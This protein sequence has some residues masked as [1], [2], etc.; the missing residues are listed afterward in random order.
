MVCTQGAEFH[1]VNERK[2]AETQESNDKPLTN[3]DL[4]ELDQLILKGGEI[5]KDDAKTGASMRV[6]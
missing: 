6:S 1:E 4:A 5:D 3:E 2:A